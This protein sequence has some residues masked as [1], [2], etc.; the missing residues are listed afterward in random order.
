[1]IVN[2]VKGLIANVSISTEEAR[3]LHDALTI[4]KLSIGEDLLVG[5]GGR[6]MGMTVDHS[7]GILAGIAGIKSGETK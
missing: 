5:Q 2:Y 7:R 6:N 4:A 3:M 1:M